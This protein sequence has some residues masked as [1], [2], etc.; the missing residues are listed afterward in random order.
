MTDA[1]VGFLRSV[2]FSVRFEE[3]AKPTFLAGIS[4]REGVLLVDRE[5]LLYP[6]D[7]LHEAGHLAVMTASERL[8]CDGEAGDHPGNE[9]AAIAWSY[10]ASLA[11]GVPAEVLFHDTGYKGGA[12]SLRESFATGRGV[13]VPMLEWLGLAAR[14]EYPVLRS[15]LRAD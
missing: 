10:A 13:G 12:A 6:G 8:A 3:L 4:I 14:G 11:A 7:L 2:G 9:M 1:I 5:K 15:W